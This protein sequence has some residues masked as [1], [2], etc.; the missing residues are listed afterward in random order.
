VHLVIDRRD[1]ATVTSVVDG[2]V[3]DRWSPDDLVAFVREREEG[4]DAPRWVFADTAT[5]YPPLS[6][7][8]VRLDR[9][10]DLRLVRAI[11]RASELTA[12]TRFASAPKDDWDAPP[13]PAAPPGASTLFDVAPSGPSGDPVEELLAQLAALADAREPQRLQRLVGAES[14]GALIASEMHS[15]GLPWNA[16]RHDALL[17]ELLGPR[18]REGDRPAVLQELTERIRLLLD[19]PRLNPDSHQELLRAL[20]G[21]G[22][23]VESTAVWELQRLRHPAIAPLVEYRKLSRLLTANGWHWLDSW[24]HGGR[25][26]PEYVP[27]GVVTGRWAT[28]GG[29]ALQLPRQVRSAVVADPGWCLVVADASQLEPRILAALADDRAMIAAGAAGDLYQGIVDSGAVAT[30]DEAKVAML[31]AMYGAT[32]GEAA[33]LMPRLT[34]AYPRA[35]G[36]VEGAARAGE[37]GEVVST[38][39]GRSSPRPRHARAEGGYGEPAPASAA[40][41]G[42][43]DDPRAWGRFTRNFV[44]QGSAAEWALCWMAS[45][46]SRL[47]ALGGTWP[48]DAPH[49]VFFVHDEIVVHTPAHL[50]DEVVTQV[51][52]AADHA[53]RLLFGGSPVRFPVT[54]AVV[55]DYSE[56]K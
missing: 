32:S 25:F 50:A 6:A 15:A 23:A 33:R 28:N 16:A 37:R 42:Y 4:P 39:L 30:R 9:V 36:L 29:G 45:V 11:L 49:L 14:M 41:G 56:A 38:R 52:E 19:A 43:A 27:G 35:I 55:D 34:R 22:L 5:G 40:P 46:R 21:A 44:V 1:G 18:P 47:R 24:V 54:V 53:G 31:G 10:H 12:H 48:T 20:R 8:G 51:R 17:T 26:R 13:Q 7:A 3:I 2:S